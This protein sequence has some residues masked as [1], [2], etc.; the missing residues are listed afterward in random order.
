MV[1]ERFGCGLLGFR[2]VVGVVNVG[3]VGVGVRCDS[4][5]CG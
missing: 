2:G 4:D 3:V 1:G 5:L